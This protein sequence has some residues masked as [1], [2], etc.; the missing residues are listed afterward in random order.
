M[1]FGNKY[2]DLRNLA[3]VLVKDRHRYEEA[4]SDKN[5]AYL[6]LCNRD[7]RLESAPNGKGYRCIW[8]WT[9][10]LHAPKY[11]P[12]L[13]IRLMKRA[14]ENH[15]IC[16]A[17]IPQDQSDGPDISFIIGHRGIDRLPNLL[18]T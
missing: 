10:D 12:R 8:K 16:R 2:R 3:G 13:G 5:Q 17:A 9:S 7:E 14:L 15:P 4:L 18:V 6:A 11:L 1:W